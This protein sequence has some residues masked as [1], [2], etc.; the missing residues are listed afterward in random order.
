[1][2]RVRRCDLPG[3]PASSS[4]GM[5]SLLRPNPGEPADLVCWRLGCAR[6]A[7][8]EKVCS[9]YQGSGSDEEFVRPPNPQSWGRQE[10]GQ[11]T[12]SGDALHKE[13]S[14]ATGKKM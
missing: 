4:D 10:Q 3:A 6:S 9:T 7:A 12:G 5:R 11:M 14:A 8:T 1:M 2:A 13:R